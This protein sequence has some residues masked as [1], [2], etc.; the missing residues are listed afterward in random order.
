[1][2]INRLILAI[3]VFFQHPVLADIFTDGTVGDASNL[4]RV[5]PIN[6]TSNGQLIINQELGSL[7]GKNLFHSFQQ[8]DI[9]RNETATFTGADTIQNV[10]SRVT[11]GEKSTINGTLRSQVGST[12][13][14][15]ADFYFINPAGVVFGE[16]AQVDVPAS[17]HIS[18]AGELI[19]ADGSSF[20]AL[21][22]EASTLT[23]ATPEAFG[24]T[25]G[26]NGSLEIIGGKL[27]FKPGTNVSLSANSLN[28]QQKA[29]ITVE[30]GPP[31]GRFGS[32][33]EP[34]IRL[35]LSAVDS[36]TTQGIP[37][38]DLTKTEATGGDLSIKDSEITV[39][40]DGSGRL[41]IRAGTVSANN[42][43]LSA[44]NIGAK[45]MSK[46]DGV[47]VH[48]GELELTATALT[49][50]TLSQGKGGVVSVTVDDAIILNGGS[51]D[52]STNGD[53]DAGNVTIT[54]EQLIIYNGEIIADS[55]S[56]GSSTHSDADA[57]DV[58][59]TAEQLTMHSG[60]ITSNTFRDGDGGSI[61]LQ[62]SGLMHLFK[63]AT[64]RSYSWPFFNNLNSE[65]SNAGSVVIVAGQLI[66]DGQGPGTFS[67][68]LVSTNVFP[69]FNLDADDSESINA[70]DAGNI[71]ITVNESMQLLNGAVI[72]SS[73]FSEGNVG[74][75]A[76]KAEQLTIDSTM[77]GGTAINT[78]ASPGSGGDAGNISITVNGLMQLVKV[79]NINSG[80]DGSGNAGNII[81]NAG[82]LTLDGAF[83]GFSSDSSGSGSAGNVTITV[84]ES[85]LI[86][87]G[88]I[89]SDALKTG[90]A[91]IVDVNA[92]E[93]TLLNE[94]RIS[95]ITSTEGRAGS[96]TIGAKK[97]TIDG[98]GEINTGIASD[99]FGSGAAGSVAVTVDESTLI[100]NGGR[101]SSVAFNAGKA[102]DV[103]VEAGTLAI[104]GLNTGIASDSFGSGIAGTVK[105]TK[106]ESMQIANEGRI[107]SEASSTGDAG[108][109]EVN[110]INEIILLDRGRISSVAFGEG[111]AGGVMVEAGKLTI[112]GQ[113]EI[114]T[115]I[116]S[117]STGALSNAGTVKIGII[118]PLKT[119]EILD[120]GQI[121]T[122][123]INGEGGDIEV[124][125]DDYIQLRNAT[126]TTSAL[127]ESSMQ[128]GNILIET[129]VLVLHNGKILAS[130][131]NTDIAD[132]RVDVISLLIASG[133]DGDS[134]TSNT[135]GNV[136]R[137]VTDDKLTVTSP[138]LNIVGALANVITPTLDIERL[139]QDP[140][141]H[142]D[143]N[144]F[145]KLGHGGA[146]AFQHGENY[147]LIN[148]F[149]ESE[150]EPN[151][152]DLLETM[153]SINVDHEN[154]ATECAKPQNTSLN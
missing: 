124:R 87:E 119:I 109:V 46:E 138:E 62:V 127:G 48:V 26:Q 76:V 68:P 43:Q 20:S 147:L 95:S 3:L 11:G 86:N 154:T 110:A 57:G 35:N 149:D 91:G 150:H 31:T 144:S 128:A 23:I 56:F 52:S 96:V 45:S 13:D 24:F 126:I 113:G 59:I 16:K 80:T 5:Q 135:E 54:T 133:D 21:N 105:V 93:I 129:P 79:A 7:E 142:G 27:K 137:A 132:G 122:S 145:K 41:G 84:D 60:N 63:N 82:K 67:T 120:S 66:M 64:I 47:D 39:S 100:I 117:L 6:P 140:C 25:S 65:K 30:H 75:I 123:S 146:P 29:S 103:T 73:T 19:F 104:D 61:E 2:K 51:I 83:A 71:S 17:F 148:R 136:I 33:E 28:I 115:G 101:I 99:S 88:R 42:S 4:G 34:G 50:R 111:H 106:N 58:S 81:V 53:G 118:N 55:G 107:S 143:E 112:D 44:N 36:L 70:G 22:P 72:Q 1:M 85:I 139:S 14:N 97:L 74:S 153:S 10:I 121:S 8:F 9:Q 116:S 69:N 108:V 77:G 38:T 94:G 37:I 114:N 40:G 125:S 152:R 15:P 130:S 131:L 89:S 32:I 134:V 141:A 90:D 49:N 78:F 12:T 92:N 98:K 102:G 151:D 18:A